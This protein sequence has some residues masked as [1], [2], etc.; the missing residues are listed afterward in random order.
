MSSSGWGR[1][2]PRLYVVVFAVLKL[3]TNEFDVIIL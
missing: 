3:A 2:S 1:C